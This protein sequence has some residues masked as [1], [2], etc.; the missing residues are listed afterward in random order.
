MLIIRNANTDETDEI[1]SLVKCTIENI[2]PKY[3]SYEAVEFFLCHHK[4]ETIK[5]DIEQQIVYVIEIDLKIV[6]TVTIKENEIARLFVLPNLQQK[7]I[8]TQLLDFAEHNILRKY[9]TIYLDSSL[10]AKEM[11]LRRG[12]KATSVHK[13]DTGN[14]EFFYYDRMEK[15][16]LIK[17]LK[18][19]K[20]RS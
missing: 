11:Y 6:G 16:G 1:V 10:P 17:Q 9:S 19:H 4:F 3:Y 20:I 14:G 2:Y 5:T 7:G 12:Y 13:I 18:K 8:G 15:L